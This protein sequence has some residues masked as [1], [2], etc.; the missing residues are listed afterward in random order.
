MHRN[1]AC[2]LIGMMAIFLLAVSYAQRV[3]ATD[4]SPQTVRAS[5]PHYD[6][7]GMLLRPQ[8]FESWVF[9]GASTG[10]SY[11]K[12][13]SAG[14]APNFHN[15]YILPE[16]Y[17]A[18]R[19][20]G[21][22]PEKTMLALAM[23]RPSEKVSPAKGGLFEGEF[24]ALEVAVKDHEKFPEGWAYYSFSEYGQQLARAEAFPKGMCYS[25]HVAHGADDNVFVQFYPVLRQLKATR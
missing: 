25:C 15:V 17:L 1:R 21:K 22:F 16:A 24:E 23:Y 5:G 12:F 6:A 9:V 14:R 11:Q 4:P 20:T 19:R 18:Y 2:Q 3:R 8:D 13:S 7:D 10:L